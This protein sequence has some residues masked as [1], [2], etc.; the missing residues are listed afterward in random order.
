M[1]IVDVNEDEIADKA[2]KII[3]YKVLNVTFDEYNECDLKR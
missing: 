3:I 1:K 2:C